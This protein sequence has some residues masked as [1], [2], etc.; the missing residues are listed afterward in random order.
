[1]IK[2][3]V[4][5]PL[6]IEA[7]YRVGSYFDEEKELRMYELLTAVERNIADDIKNKKG[8]LPLVIRVSERSTDDEW[9]VTA[10]IF[11]D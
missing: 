4:T 2:S 1:M 11:Y 7:E 9:K 10:E 6:P 8:S 3:L 5:R